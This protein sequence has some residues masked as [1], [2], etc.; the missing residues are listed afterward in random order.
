MDISLT[1]E[2][3]RFVEEKVAAGQFS[4][5]SEVIVGALTLLKESEVL[6]PEALEELRRD[7]QIGLDQLDRGLGARWDAEA[8]KA[9]VRERVA[10]AREG[11]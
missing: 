8:T 9:R 6:T 3:E 5:S 4:S 10:R 2:L 7:I 1:P 11:R